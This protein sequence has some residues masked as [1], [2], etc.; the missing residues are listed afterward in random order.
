[1]KIVSDGRTYGGGTKVFNDEGKEIE[2][3]Q[4]IEITADANGSGRVEAKLTFIDI[5]L[6]IKC[7]VRVEMGIK[8]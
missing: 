4:K 7:D 1:M 2:G 8:V 5:E 3:I 6:D